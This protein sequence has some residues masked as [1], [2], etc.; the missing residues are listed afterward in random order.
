MENIVLLNSKHVSLCLRGKK[1]EVTNFSTWGGQSKHGRTSTANTTSLIL[2]YRD[3]FKH[4][5]ICCL[6]PSQMK[7]WRTA[8]GLTTG[9]ADLPLGSKAR[10]SSRGWTRAYSQDEQHLEEQK[11]R[12]GDSIKKASKKLGFAT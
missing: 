5:D 1:G 7:E 4:K 10:Q 11:Q 3:D 2:Q 9:P 6:L 12:K 8:A